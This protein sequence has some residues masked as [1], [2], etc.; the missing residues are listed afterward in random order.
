MSDLPPPSAPPPPGWYPD[1]TTG[2]RGFRWWDGSTW[3]D[4]WSEWPEADV[5][6]P[7]ALAPVGEWFNELLGLVSGRAGHL[8]TLIVVVLVPITLVNATAA[9]YAFRGL[10]V[11]VDEDAGTVSAVND[12]VGVELYAAV[13]GTYLLMVLASVLLAVAATRQARAQIEE[14]PEP[15]SESAI[16]GLRRLGRATGNLFVVWLCLFALYLVLVIGLALSPVLLLVLLPLWLAGSF[17]IAIRFA[18]AATAAS[19]APSGVG[20]LATSRRLTSGRVTGLLG[21]MMLLGLLSVSVWLLLRLI[22]TPFV[23]LAGGGDAAPL[24]PGATEIAVGDLLGDNPATFAVGQLFG[25]L[26][27][28]AALVLWAAGLALLYRDLHGPLAADVASDDL[29]SD[30]LAISD[31]H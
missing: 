24:D 8:F 5:E 13:A 29:A 31:G 16:G 20:S 9:Y 6:Q 15:W 2:G 26:G 1:P 17:W 11:T 22:A 27:S 21:R 4:Q 25:A 30:D 12:G 14:R 28:G 3:T 18:F 19:L 10:V 23:A 7:A